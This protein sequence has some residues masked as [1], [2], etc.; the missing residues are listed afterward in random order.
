[1]SAINIVT[2][3]NNFNDLK[4][5]SVIADSLIIRFSIYTQLLNNVRLALFQNV[6]YNDYEILLDEISVVDNN[7]TNFINNYSGSLTSTWS[8]GN[9]VIQNR[10]ASNEDYLCEDAKLE[11]LCRLNQKV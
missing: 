4:A 8:F 7:Y 10:D 9:L 2:S 11:S 3:N 5:T 1:M 6:P